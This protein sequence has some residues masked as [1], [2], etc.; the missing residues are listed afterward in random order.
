M[1]ITLKLLVLLG[2][3]TATVTGV[4]MLLFF[5]KFMAFNEYVNQNILLRSKYDFHAFGFD[6]WLFG[7]SFL[8]A[9]IMLIIGLGL[10][11]Q[12]VR[13]APYWQ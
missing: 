3:I 5:E 13:Y 12:F 4:A 9:V 1:V 11:T 7:R 2:G 6:S 10:L 8:V